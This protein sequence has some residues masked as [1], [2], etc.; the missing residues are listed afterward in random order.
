MLHIKPLISMF[1]FALELKTGFNEF[2][3]EP[4]LISQQYHF[5]KTWKLRENGSILVTEAF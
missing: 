2:T 1:I 4:D 3:L 5:W